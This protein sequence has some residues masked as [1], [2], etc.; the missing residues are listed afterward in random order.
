MTIHAL[1]AAAPNSSGTQ[2]L[3][4][5]RAATR[6]TFL[7]EC[8]WDAENGVLSPPRDHPLLGLR[9]CAREGC[10]AGVRSQHVELCQTCEKKLQSSGLSLAEFVVDA[11]ATKRANRGERLCIV[12]RCERPSHTYETLCSTHSTARRL[13]RDLSPA[14]WIAREEPAPLPSHGPCRVPGCIR[15]AAMR[16]GL[17]TPHGTR[18]GV[19][20]RRAGL[21]QQDRD[22]LA[23]WIKRQEPIGVDHLVILT[24]LHE[25]LVAEL[26]LGLQHRCDEGAR[27]QLT[28]LRAVVKAARSANV[29]NLNDLTQ[30]RIPRKRKDARALITNLATG[31]R[32][33][34][35]TPESEFALDVWDLATF[36][37]KGY[38]DFRAISQTWLRDTAKHWAA[39][40]LPMHRGR[41][42][43]ATAKGVVGALG[44]LSESL[45]VTR[46]D[47]GEHPAQLG[48]R[49]IVNF[50]NRLK[51]FEHVGSMTP[52]MRLRTIRRVR[53]ALDDAR[54]F[55]TASGGVLLTDLPHDFKVMRADVPT[56]PA[57]DGP[58][59]DLPLPV[60]R[61]VVDSLHVL[62]ARPRGC[63]DFDHDL[64]R[65]DQI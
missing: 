26:L 29:T 48:R 7:V 62:E 10:L 56:E 50:S 4:A 11:G 19:A 23:E 49:D 16:V 15:V 24:E 53:R 61:T 21:P 25:N 42:S 34:L 14:Q 1:A 43:G 47:H 40:D 12:P 5:L 38:L 59:R 6:P 20:R 52:P 33:S 2:R 13:H 9:K 3:E 30:V 17:C 63:H 32:R 64:R 57:R 31:V 45:R 51:H 8:G 46:E 41:Q 39:E 60:L 58:G 28:V 54:G 27:T 35:A 65:C 44:Y 55:H 22:A 36:G 18:W 37:A